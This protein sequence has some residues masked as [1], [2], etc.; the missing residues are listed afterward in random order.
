MDDP[1]GIDGYLVT[2]VWLGLFAY[3]PIAGIKQAGSLKAWLRSC[4]QRPFDAIGSLLVGLGTCSFLL[5]ILTSGLAPVS[6]SLLAPLGFLI[7]LI[8]RQL[9]KR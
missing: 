6:L 5:W 2:L 8:D 7:L 3:L 4:V 9:S 1:N